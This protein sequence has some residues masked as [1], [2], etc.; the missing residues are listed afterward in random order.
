MGTSYTF[1]REAK[2]G[3]EMM[4]AVVARGLEG[5]VS[6]ATSLSEVDG[7]AG[8]LTIGGYDI[9]DLVGRVSFE[10]AAYLLWYGALPDRRQ[11]DALRQRMA[12]A[13]RL[14][15]AILDVLRGPA[16]EASGMHALR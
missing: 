7:L 11:L 5:I 3:D 2:V 13:R 16:H 1:S 10:E 15:A 14:P 6:H 8:R 12:Q 9:H 4:Q